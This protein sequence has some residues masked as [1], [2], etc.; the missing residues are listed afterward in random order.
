MGGG[1]G[2]AQSMG[3][4]CFL[5]A[6]ALPAAP[7]PPLWPTLHLGTSLGAEPTFGGAPALRKILQASAN[8]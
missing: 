3:D 4:G 5:R 1:D 8:V 6:Q 7:L 2:R